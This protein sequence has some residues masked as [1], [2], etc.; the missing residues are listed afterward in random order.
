[1][2]SRSHLRGV[3]RS[4]RTLERDAMDAMGAFDEWRRRGRRS[5][6]V[7][8]TQCRCRRWLSGLVRRGEHEGSRNTIARGMPGISGVTV[9]TTLVCFVFQNCMRGCGRIERPAFPAPSDCR[10]RDF[11]QKLAR[12]MRRD[13][14]V[15]SVDSTAVALLI[16]HRTELLT[17]ADPNAISTPPGT[18]GL[19]A[20]ELEWRNDGIDTIERRPR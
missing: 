17:F 6:V 4:S 20:F 15:V 7:L 3:S 2:G 14:D 19:S 11:R 1:M 12:N 10:R 8:D 9:V 13:R 5:R 16:I 18:S